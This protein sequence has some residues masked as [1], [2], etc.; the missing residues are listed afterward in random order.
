ML[1]P[2]VKVGVQSFPIH[3]WFRKLLKSH[4]TE[5]APAQAPGI[6]IF[7]ITARTNWVL[8]EQV[9]DFRFGHP[10]RLFWSE[11]KQWTGL[12]LTLKTGTS[13]ARNENLRPVLKSGLWLV[14]VVSNL[15]TFDHW[16]VIFSLF[17]TLYR[18]FSHFTYLWKFKFGKR[19]KDFTTKC[20]IQNLFIAVTWFQIWLWK[21]NWIEIYNFDLFH[22]T[23]G[24]S[25]RL[26][27]VLIM[28]ENVL[29]P[30]LLTRVHKQVY[31][32]AI[33]VLHSSYFELVNMN[34]CAEVSC[35]GSSHD[36]R[37]K[38]RKTMAA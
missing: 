31:Y 34:Q 4:L 11:E 32:I 36:V 14:I 16:K 13:G 28:Q 8:S 38:N 10:K 37:E 2:L 20:V 15:L 9:S 21:L 6:E 33:F 24:G 18:A 3:C 30:I 7:T 25:L 1:L 26:P 12:F 22:C 17:L 35:Q 29:D 27:S 5:P 19:R 23:L